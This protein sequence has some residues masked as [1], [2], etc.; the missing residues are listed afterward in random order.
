M[1]RQLLVLI[2]TF[3]VMATSAPASE[4][5]LVIENA[6][7]IVGNGTVLE[8]AF[9]VVA[10]NRIVSVDT[11]PVEFPAADRIDAAG[12]TVLPGLIDTHVHLLMEQLFEQ[13]RS[14][15]ALESFMADRL[16]GRLK[17]YL[18]AG[19]TTVMSTGDYWPFI[20]EVRR[21]I[22]T[23]RLAGP[24]LYTAGPLF[25]APGG[26]PAST[27]CGSLDINGP[28][29]WC[30]EHLVVEVDDQDEATAAVGRLSRDGADLIKMVYDGTDGPDVGMLKTEV[31][32]A[33]VSAAHKHGLRTYAHSLEHAS[34]IAAIER[35][36]DGL[37]HLPAIASSPEEID[38]LIQ[39]MVAEE[40]AASTTLTVF[41]SLAGI[42][43]S[44][45]NEEMS[46]AMRG[47][48][49]SMKQTLAGL[50]AVDAGLIVLGTDAP[51]LPPG[52][53]YF[54]E[55]ELLAAAGLAPEQIIR[56]ASRDA[57]RY[58]GLGD[59]LGT[60]EPGKLADLIIVAGD[61]L[62]D[63]SALRAIVLVVRDGEVAVS[64]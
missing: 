55:I 41:D 6:R 32:E 52:E 61:P 20:E 9:I 2:P 33:I 17:A 34:A 24:R 3:A 53:A 15:T 22:D 62:M 14:D 29:P 37:V 44:Q 49:E 45:G 42:A 25:T 54:R 31:V 63:L 7:V 40:V 43:S 5:T 56:A 46:Q 19:I 16:P 28:N 10:G 57:A 13:P 23:G 18:E 4:A 8:R 21:D 50:C 35:G 36:L 51:H 27:F 39:A 48:V 47:L 60:L 26:H 38:R 30:R 59:E 12:N 1:L 64:R 58:M 11:E